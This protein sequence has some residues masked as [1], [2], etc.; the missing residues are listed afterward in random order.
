MRSIAKV[1]LTNLVA[2]LILISSPVIFAEDHTVSQSAKGFSDIFLTVKVNEKVSFV[3]EDSAPHNVTTVEKNAKEDHGII[4]PGQKQI[5]K[6]GKP[7]VFE[8]IC[9]MH[10]HKKMTIFVKQ[11]LASN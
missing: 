2:L 5:V 11:S 8:V 3:N 9:K 4:K 10:K 6:F 7:G 1:A